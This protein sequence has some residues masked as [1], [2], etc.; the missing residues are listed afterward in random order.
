MFEQCIAVVR[1]LPVIRFQLWC[2]LCLITR[3]PRKTVLNYST[4]LFT[5]KIF[6]MKN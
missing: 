1:L 2:I 4:G 6:Q 3:N 5:V